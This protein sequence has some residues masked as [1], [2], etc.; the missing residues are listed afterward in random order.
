M[1]PE[2]CVHCGATEHVSRVQLDCITWKPICDE[3]RRQLDDMAQA[4][5][6]QLRNLAA[7]AKQKKEA[8]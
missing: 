6:W 4:W 8:A 5:V 7:T 2:P 3:C 1:T